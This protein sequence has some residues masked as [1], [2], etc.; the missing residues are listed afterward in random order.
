MK[1]SCP[2]MTGQVDKEWMGNS[3]EY[4]DF[5]FDVQIA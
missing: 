2:E 5:G 3:T 4:L 1:K